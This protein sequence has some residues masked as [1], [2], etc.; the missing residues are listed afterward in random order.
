MRRTGTA[1]R[2]SASAV[3][4]DLDHVVGLCESPIEEALL[5]AELYTLRLDNHLLMAYIQI[6]DTAPRVLSGAE[7]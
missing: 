2:R 1:P 6:I 7:T 5:R 3:K 4:S